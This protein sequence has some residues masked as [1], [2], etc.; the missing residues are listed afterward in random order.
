MRWGE[1]ELCVLAASYATAEASRAYPLVAATVEFSGW[2]RRRWSRS[3]RRA[4]SPKGRKARQM[5]MLM[6][7]E[8]GL[9][10]GIGIGF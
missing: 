2:I 5:R 10:I 4:R 8:N 7:T 3:G 6:R 1:C 9:R